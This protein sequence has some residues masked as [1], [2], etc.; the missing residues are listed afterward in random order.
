MG[1]E[2]GEKKLGKQAIRKTN[3]YLIRQ[4]ARK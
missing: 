4:K 2:K 1:Q 3:R